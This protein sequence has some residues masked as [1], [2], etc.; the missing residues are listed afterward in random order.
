[1]DSFVS[2]LVNTQPKLLGRRSP[3]IGSVAAP[4]AGSVAA[5]H[6]GS[7]AAP[8]A[9]LFA[10]LV[11]TAAEDQTNTLGMPQMSDRFIVEAVVRSKIDSC[12]KVP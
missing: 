3:Y 5:P 2:V 6:A 7:V 8:H 4:H 12:S 10:P 1:M 11:R 9:G